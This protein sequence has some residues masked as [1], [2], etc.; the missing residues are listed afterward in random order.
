M[1]Q[2]FNTKLFILLIKCLR[3]NVSKRLTITE[4]QTEY[5]RI[6]EQLNADF[7]KSSKMS[8]NFNFPEINA[9]LQ[10]DSGINA[11]D[12]LKLQTANNQVTELLNKNEIN[13]TVNMDNE[14][15]Q[16][17]PITPKTKKNTQQEPKPRKP[18]TKK[19]PQQEPKPRKP[20]TKKVLQQENQPQEIQ[21]QEIQPQ[22]IQPQENQGGKS[23]TAKISCKKTK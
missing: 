18:R 22:E 7:I 9:F 19:V 16:P 23:R 14:L 17:K 10:E 12:V 2:N 15:T 5:E 4:A 21:P 20:R 6:L 13:I 11:A 8:D 1:P 3:P